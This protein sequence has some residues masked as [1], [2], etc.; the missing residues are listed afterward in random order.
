[1]TAATTP[2][3]TEN[4]IARIDERRLVDT[5]CSYV[6]TPSPTGSEEAMAETVRA[7]FEDT[8]LTVTWQEVEDGR[9]NVIGTLDGAGGGASLMFN[10]HMDTSYSGRESHLRHIIGFQPDAVVKE[11]RI[12]GL[13]I[14]NMKGALACYLEAV[15][16][17]KDAGLKLRGDVIIA[18]VVGE[19]EKT[20]WGEEF[21]GREYR[22][23][24]T[25]SR[26]LPVHGGIA[27]M[28]I[29]G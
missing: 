25:G 28:C 2:E 11:G 14:S 6:S 8:G 9:P 4:V 3:L 22:G 19:I 12:Y 5:A 27:D 1:M 20:Q 29:L 10:G 13:G 26:H 7:A 24:A 21:R 16:A 23:Y 18:C 15:R 17:I